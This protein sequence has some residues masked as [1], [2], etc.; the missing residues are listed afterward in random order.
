M[1]L[2]NMILNFLFKRQKW[3]EIFAVFIYELVLNFLQ[4]EQNGF[5]RVIPTLQF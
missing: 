2:R 1:K 3:I 5:G 4:K